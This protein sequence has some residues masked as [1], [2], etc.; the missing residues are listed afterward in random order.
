M[1]PLTIADQVQDALEHL[2]DYAYLQTRP[3]ST[4]PPT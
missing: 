1:D 3:R 2:Y 4:P